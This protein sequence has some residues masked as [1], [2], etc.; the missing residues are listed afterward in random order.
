MTSDSLVSIIPVYNRG[1]DL[2]EVADSALAQIYNNIEA[3][4]VNE[5]PNGVVSSAMNLGIRKVFCQLI[6]GIRTGI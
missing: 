3:L 2:R 1:N 5:A 4:G 6:S